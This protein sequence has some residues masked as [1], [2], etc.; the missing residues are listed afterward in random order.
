MQNDD[1]RCIV[2]QYKEGRRWVI[3]HKKRKPSRLALFIYLSV[4]ISGIAHISRKY[5]TG[6]KE[7]NKIL[8][9]CKDSCLFLSR[10]CWF[11]CFCSCFTC[12]RALSGTF[13]KIMEPGRIRVLPKGGNAGSCGL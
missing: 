7:T 13:G 9:R 12:C 1:F 2:T 8:N 10:C 5:E 4:P 6:Q 3:T 11:C